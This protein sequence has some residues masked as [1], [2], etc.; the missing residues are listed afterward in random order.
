[1][2]R[3]A[4][5]ASLALLHIEHYGKADAAQRDQRHDDQHHDGIV[6]VSLK[7][8]RQVKARVAEGGNGVKD[9]IPYAPRH[10]V[11]GNQPSHQQHRANALNGQ[12]QPHDAHHQPHHALQAVLI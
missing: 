9:R 10:A 6:A 2:Q 5:K 8:A 3:Q 12:R 7:S 11:L 4:G 1:M